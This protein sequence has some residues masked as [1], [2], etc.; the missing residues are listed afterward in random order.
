MT[1]HDCCLLLPVSKYVRSVVFRL[2]ASQCTALSKRG[3][4]HAKLLCHREDR[5]GLDTPNEV[6]FFLL[7]WITILSDRFPLSPQSRGGAS[8]IENKTVIFPPWI[9][10]VKNVHFLE[11]RRRPKNSLKHSTVIKSTK[12]SVRIC[13]TAPPPKAS[14]WA[15]IEDFSLFCRFCG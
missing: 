12:M 5:K 14:R 8:W 7:R 11:C 1:G 13:V 3:R 15:V 4:G 10:Y 6:S 2:P 9:D